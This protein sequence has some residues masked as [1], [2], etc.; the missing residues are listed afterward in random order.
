MEQI[1]RREVLAGTAGMVAAALHPFTANLA[2]QTESRPNI[3]WFVSEDNTPLIGAYGNKLV[4]T[5]TIDRLAREGILYRNAYCTSPVCGP[6]RFAII[7]GMFAETAAPANNMGAW[8][9][10]PSIIK[11]YP[12]YLRQAGYYCTNN[13]KKNYQSNLDYADFWDESSEKAHWRNGPKGKPFFAIFNTFTTHESCLFKPLE[14]RV[15]P[16]DVQLPAYLPDTPGV[17]QDLVTF[18]NAMEKMDGE[19]AA[20]LAELEADGVSE[21]TIVFYYSDNG[22]IMPR[23]KRFCYDMGLRCALVVY[24]PKKWAHLAPVKMGSVVTSPVSFVDLAPTLLS[25]LGLPIPRYTQGEAFLGSAAGKPQKYAFGM[26]NRMDER[27]DMMRTVMDGRY[28]YIRN[29][30]PHRIW[31]QHGAFMWQ[32][33]SYQDW[34]TAHIA[35]TLNPAQERFWQKKVFEEFYDT[36]TDPDCVSNLIAEPDQQAR[37]SEMRAALD[38]HMIEVND[39]GFI[40]DGC[41]IE[42]YEESRKAGSYPLRRIMDVAGIAAKGDAANLSRLRKEL[43]DPN[44]ILRYWAAQG[45][46]VLGDKAKDAIPEM[47]KIVAD[48]ESI[49]VRIV[50]AETL[51]K[52]TG[53]S[54]AMK[55]LIRALDKNPNARVRLQAINALTY[56]GEKA[57]VALGEIQNAAESDDEYLRDAGRY[58]KFLLEGTYT[59]ASPCYDTEWAAGVGARR[60]MLAT[61]PK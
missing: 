38:A 36:Q 19:L 18:Y 35:G 9:E 49:H 58:L 53:D 1:S 16:E 3:L 29:Y 11:G 2:A 43:S 17:R 54:E 12:F 40:P 31:G 14:G 23:G 20:R 48:D 24:F 60:K 7:T 8:T 34:E 41:P 52:L 22:G 4:H 15:K 61:P 6:S 26:R 44:E 32:A 45:L 59:P 27:Y 42:G 57:R 47:Q 50:A 56:V 13:A 25:L 5:P 28:H 39:N 55:L 37:I 33:R 46:L 30:S 51:V 10:L 21:D